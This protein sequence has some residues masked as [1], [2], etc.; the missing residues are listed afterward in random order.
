MRRTEDEVDTA[1]LLQSLEGDTGEGTE[2]VAVGRAEAVEVA[3]GAE[4]ANVVDSR[5]DLG[6]LLSDNVRVGRGLQD[7]GEGALRSLIL[8]GGD[9][10]T[11]RFR[12]ASETTG[13]DDGP[14]ELNTDGDGPRS[15][16]VAVLGGVDDDGGDEETDCG[17]GRRWISFRAKCEM[18][19][20][21]RGTHS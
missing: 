5:G 10:V 1:K 2:T 14:G 20:V 7:T 6:V 21:L 3:G 12:E 13:E 18:V 15:L 11:G 17:R 16:V 4:R 9:E 8:A 19:T